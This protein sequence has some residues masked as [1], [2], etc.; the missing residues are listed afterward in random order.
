MT[1]EAHDR[2]NGPLA[3]DQHGLGGF[4]CRECSIQHIYDYKTFGLEFVGYCSMSD[5]LS[6]GTYNNRIASIYAWLNQK[7]K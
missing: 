3:F 1:H 7:E 4:K 5:D 6:I 2:P